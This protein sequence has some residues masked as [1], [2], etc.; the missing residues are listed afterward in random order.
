MSLHVQLSPRAIENLHRERRNSTIL[1]IALSF[2]IVAFILV[3][4]SFFILPIMIKETPTIVTYKSPEK[5]EESLDKKRVTTTVV[6]KPSAPANTITRVI[7]TSNP[8]LLS[9]PVPD[10]DV[11]VPAPDFGD[12]QSFGGGW[13]SAG[14]F[15]SGTAGIGG[16]GGFGT[17]SAKSGGLK[18][19]IYDLKQS[20]KGNP[21]PY[22][23]ASFVISA[24]SLIENQFEDSAFNDYFKAP[25]PLYLTRLAVPMAPAE[26]GPS[27]FD[28][29]KEIQPRGWIAHYSGTVTVPK[30][31]TYRFSG[32]GDDFV[33]VMINSKTVFNYYQTLESLDPKSKGYTPEQ[34]TS[35]RGAPFTKAS[36]WIRYGEWVELR[37]G[38]QIKLDIAVGETPGGQVGFLLQL[39]E[40][41]VKY[42]MTSDGNPIL[43]LFTT[44][45]ISKKEEKELK[46]QYGDYKLD[47]ENVLV[48]PQ[49]R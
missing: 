28:A 20:P 41:G 5:V 11:T 12:G 7:A 15:G 36:W 43:P 31:G 2:I 49:K 38:Q 48:F 13:G 35:R 1:S 47:F 17:S 45:P 22:S 19:Y 23:P 21:L 25:T 27:F 40:K 6:R 29:E 33:H 14:D 4:L 26:D 39:E 42:E 16:G 34:P 8:S 24:R 44:A 9:I 32:G 3:V 18:G 30:T 46:E 37:A 10:V